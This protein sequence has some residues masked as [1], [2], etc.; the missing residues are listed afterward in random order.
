MERGGNGA[1]VGTLLAGT[2]PI[3]RDPKHLASPRYLWRGH[4]T[5]S[6]AEN[7][8][9]V[10]VTPMSSKQKSPPK[11]RAKLPNGAIARLSKALECS[12]R[13]AQTLVKAGCPIDPLEAASWRK[14]QQDP[15]GANTA[16]LLRKARVKLVTEQERRIKLENDVR[17]GQ[18]IDCEQVDAES[19]HTGLAVRGALLALENSLAGSLVG[20]PHS[21][22]RETLH[23]EFHKVL[24]LLHKGRYYDSPGVLEHVLKFYPNYVERV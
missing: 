15:G 23:R 22:I 17:A 3:W 9:F 13:H 20:L 14:A 2:T 24:S 21:K 6:I 18:L 5:Y 11:P 4:I 12:P 8:H 10:F 16:E 7:L 19:I 1:A